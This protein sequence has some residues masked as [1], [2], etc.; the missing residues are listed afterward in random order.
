MASYL[1]TG[2]G[3]GLGLEILKVLAAKPDSEVS[4]IFGTLR[5]S[6]SAAL[7]E[8]VAKA[9]GRVVLVHLEAKDA[10]S[11]LAAVDKVK[12]CLG[13]RGLDVLINNAAISAV[14]PEGVA[15]M[16]DLR[17]TLEVNVE[18]VHSLTAACLRLLRE[19]KRKTVLN[20]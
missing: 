2:V 6:P 1:V 19:G 14:T 3:R 12:E 16:T 8:I 7:Q 5:S 17:E 10:N 4:T 9:D 13:G 20:M 11:I 15:A 18:A